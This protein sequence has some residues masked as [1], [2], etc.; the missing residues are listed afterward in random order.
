M[1][2]RSNCDLSPLQKVLE[3]SK[4]CQVFEKQNLTNNC[5]DGLFISCLFF[6]ERIKNNKHRGKYMKFVLI[7]CPIKV[8]YFHLAIV[9]DGSF[10]FVPY[11]FESNALQS[12]S[13][14]PDPKPF[15]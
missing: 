15:L 3:L 4:M 8:K 11:N 10:S 7:T 6:S 5:T 2:E 12:I 14:H 9:I 13:V 1:V